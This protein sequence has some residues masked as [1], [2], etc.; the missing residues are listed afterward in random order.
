M[1]EHYPE[2]LRKYMGEERVG[3]VKNYDNT[4]KQA[5]DICG[6]CQSSSDAAKEPE[7]ISREERSKF[8]EKVRGIEESSLMRFAHEKGLWINEADFLKKY[9]NRFIGE[10]AEQKVYLTETGY[11]VLKVNKGRFH[12]TW[13]EYFNR[14]LF[15]A[16]IFPATKYT[17]IGFTQ[18]DGIFSVVTQ[19]QFALLNNGATRDKVE[20]YLKIHGFERFKNDDYYNRNISVK[21]EDLHDENVF[22]NENNYLLFVDPVIYFETSDLKLKGEFIFHFPF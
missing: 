12:G 6:R 16:F 4:T 7:P 20:N 5:A 14:L 19:Q 17:T 9:K 18:D 3:G 11:E 15:H 21:L 1:E 2:I 13:L 10:G 8:N 22:V